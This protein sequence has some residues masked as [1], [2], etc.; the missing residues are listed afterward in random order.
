MEIVHSRLLR[1]ARSGLERRPDAG[2]QTT[3]PI[4]VRA[5]FLASSLLA[6]LTWWLDNDMP[7]SPERMDEMYQELTRTT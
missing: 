3:V 7:Y 5:G 4:E 1:H 6:L 2:D